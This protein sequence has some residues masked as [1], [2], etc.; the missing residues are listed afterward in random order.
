TS[1]SKNITEVFE[2]SVS[3]PCRGRL[4]DWVSEYWRPSVQTAS[5][6]VDVIEYEINEEFSPEEGPHWEGDPRSF[7][8]L[9]YEHIL[10]NHAGQWIEGTLKEPRH[11]AQ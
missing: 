4:V 10:A 3:S 8:F 9:P 7:S 1:V 5:R 2:R 11:A 6:L